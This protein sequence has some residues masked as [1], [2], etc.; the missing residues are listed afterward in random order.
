MFAL[1]KFSYRE[2]AN[3]TA[4]L[5]GVPGEAHAKPFVRV[6]RAAV[7]ALGHRVRRLRHGGGL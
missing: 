2:R 7:R 3:D 4:I 5:A 6:A 1:L